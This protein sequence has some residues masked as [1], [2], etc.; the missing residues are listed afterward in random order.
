MQTRRLSLL[1][2]VLLWTGLSV[3]GCDDK[4]GVATAESNPNSPP[5]IAVSIVEI[6][7]VQMQDVI[8]LPGTTEAWQDVQ[9]AADTAGRIEWIGPREG[10]KVKKGDL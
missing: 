2:A 9:V 5:A 3:M 6:Q 10:E 4:D 8:Y 7:P 1:L